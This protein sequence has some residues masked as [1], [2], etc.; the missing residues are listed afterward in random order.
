MNSILKIFLVT[1]I[2]LSSASYAETIEIDVDLNTLCNTQDNNS[3]TEEFCAEMSKHQDDQVGEDDKDKPKEEKPPIKLVQKDDK[4]NEW[5]FNLSFGYTRTKYFDT[6]VHFQ[7]DKMDVNVKKFG[8]QE[9]HSFN[10]F[11]KENLKGKGNTF[12]FF[13]EP[14]NSAF[15]SAKKG[16]NVITVSMLH[17]KYLKE[18]NQVRHVTGTIKGNEVDKDMM[19]NSRD[20]WQNDDRAAD[21]MYLY[22]FENTWQQTTVQVGYGR[23]LNLIKKK[24]FRLNYTPSMNIGVMS[25]K[26]YSSYQKDGAYWDGDA[27]QDNWRIHGITVS[28]GNRFD[29]KY[30]KIGVF[31][32]Q[33]LVITK[34]KN[35]I[36]DNGTATYNLMFIPVTFGMTI[37]LNGPKKKQTIIGPQ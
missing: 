31:L 36:M 4:G 2:L 10:Y 27:K 9:R 16:K 1:A 28:Q 20:D 18:T 14:T 13:D 24:N 12:R 15:L 37:D 21:N 11:R 22:R 25:G 6:D 8:M 34:V 17:H 19:I 33:K 35:Q 5:I 26:T 3:D 7:T 30:K 23:E 32:D 29:A